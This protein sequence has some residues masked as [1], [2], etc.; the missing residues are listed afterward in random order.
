M[1][2]H[3]ALN[4]GLLESVYQ[5]A[6]HL[7]LLDMGIDNECEK[8]IQIYYKEHLLDKTYKMD[9]VVDDVVVELK[10]V[11]Q[12]LP[13]HRAQLCNYLRLTKKPV[14]LLINFGEK[15]LIGERWAYD[16][17]TNDCVLVDRNM[18]PVGDANYNMLLYHGIVDEDSYIWNAMF[19][20]HNDN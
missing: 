2:V 12:I 11:T 15:S 9:V 17:E 6:I 7:E 20:P 10:S 14:G 18:E 16:K 4:Y 1:E 13:A 3:R 8:K 5:E 19:Q